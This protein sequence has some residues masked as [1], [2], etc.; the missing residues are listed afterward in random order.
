MP[1]KPMNPIRR[2]RWVFVIVLIFVIVK[3][4]FLT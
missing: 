3:M 1:E 2:S 4:A